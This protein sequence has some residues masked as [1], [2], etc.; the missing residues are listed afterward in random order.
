METCS[1]F[2]CFVSFQS[3]KKVVFDIVR[4]S[5]FFVACV[6]PRVPLVDADMAAINKAFVPE[7]DFKETSRQD[8]P[9]SS[10]KG[11][12]VCHVDIERIDDSNAPKLPQI[13]AT[14]PGNVQKCF[15]FGN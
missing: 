5:S 9:T 2:F 4:I 1:P 10:D 15:A 12:T 3:E 8:R 14:L 13:L 11:S 7:D 6:F